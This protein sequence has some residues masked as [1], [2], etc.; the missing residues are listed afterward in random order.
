V[1][2]VASGADTSTVRTARDNYFVRLDVAPGAPPSAPPSSGGR[3][4]RSYER[5]KGTGYE[6]QPSHHRH[7]RKRVSGRRVLMVLALVGL[8]AWLSW[9]AQQ[10]GGVNG[11]VSGFIAHVRGDV[12][13]ASSGPDLQNA[14]KHYDAIYVQGGTYPVLSEDQMTA[15][16]I[17]LD[18]DIAYCSSQAVVLRTLTVSRMLIA[19]K[20]LGEVGGHQECP[21][22]LDRPLPWKIK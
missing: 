7:R 10:P 8:V 3:S 22:N 4:R 17:A 15:A 18:V 20:D 19:G 12:Q 5:P 9:A 14:A 21:A 1:N 6:H 2:F 16:G 11:T 13:D